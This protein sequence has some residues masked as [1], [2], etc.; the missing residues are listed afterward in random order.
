MSDGQRLDKW[1]WFARFCKTRGLAQKLCAAGHVK[2]RG[3]SLVKPSTLVRPGD[4]LTVLMGPVR[5]TVIVRLPG[6]RR[7]P[8]P[9]AQTLYEEPAPPE[10]LRDPVMDGSTPA[11]RLKGTGRPTKKERRQTE[12]LIGED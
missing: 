3:E 2:R 10:R 1:L 8:A 9:E 5:R 4:E 11:H 6:E 12:R 7:G